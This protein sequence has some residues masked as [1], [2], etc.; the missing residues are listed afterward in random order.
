MAMNCDWNEEV[1]AQFYA[2]LYVRHETKTFHWLLQGKPLS[3]SYERFSQ[4]LGFGEDDLGRPKIHGGEIPLDSEMAFIYDAANGKVEF[5]TTHGMKPVYR[6]LNQLFRYTLT[7]K[8]GDN[9]SIANIAKDVLVRMGP[10]HEPFSVFDFIWEE[11]IVCSMSANK[12]CQYAP[13]IFRM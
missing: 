11:I 8:I 5:G 3:I 10:D 4:I 12:S 6:M 13:W 7:P 2:N 9:Y 1:V